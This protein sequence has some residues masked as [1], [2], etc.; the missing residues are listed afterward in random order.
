V[1][2]QIEIGHAQTVERR[3]RARIG[4]ER[5]PEIEYCV[6]GAMDRFK[7]LAELFLRVG[8]VGLIV[9]GALHLRLILR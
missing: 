4:V 9:G 3:D 6:A 2:L 1:I 8:I 7:N 5:P